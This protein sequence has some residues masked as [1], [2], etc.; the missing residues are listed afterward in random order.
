VL[1]LKFSPPDDEQLV[2]AAAAN[3]AIRVRQIENIKAG[4][5]TDDQYILL[6]CIFEAGACVISGSVDKIILA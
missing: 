2:A 3:H 4:A 5:I 6:H 1:G